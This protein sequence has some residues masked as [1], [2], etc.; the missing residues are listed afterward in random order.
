MTCSW[1]CIRACISSGLLACGTL[2]SVC[3]LSGCGADDAPE[4]GTVSG[5]V[6]LGGK[7]LPDANIIFD[8]EEGPISMGRTDESGRYE[9]RYSFDDLG[10]VPGRHTV[11]ISTGDDGSEPPV[12]EQVPAKYNHLSELTEEVKPGENN[13]NFDL[14]SE[15]M[16]IQPHETEKLERLLYQAGKM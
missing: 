9:L 11:H 14:N 7:P 4:L 1:R 8:P 12:S 16:V 6:L 3:L 13:I 5:T 2:F 15:G 10:A